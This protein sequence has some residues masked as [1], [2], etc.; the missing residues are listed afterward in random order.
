M[1]PECQKPS[2]LVRAW[3]DGLC[4][5]CPEIRSNAGHLT[6]LS[7]DDLDSLVFAPHATAGASFQ[8]QLNQLLSDCPE[9]ARCHVEG[10]Q[11]IIEAYAC[12]DR[13]A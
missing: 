7:D 9:D 10:L 1:S 3:I 6:G 2:A 12:R 13:R 8:E 5:A 11:A 4:L